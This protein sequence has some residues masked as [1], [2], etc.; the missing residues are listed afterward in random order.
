[1][2][3]IEIPRC[4]FTEYYGSAASIS[5]I[6]YYMNVLRSKKEFPFQ[7]TGRKRSD[8]DYARNMKQL[9]LVDMRDGSYFLTPR[10]QSILIIDQAVNSKHPW[11]N[12]LIKFC[13][14]KSLADFD[15][16][17]IASILWY[18]QV[19][20]EKSN[21]LQELFFPSSS[22]RN[23]RDHWLRLHL[24]L[25]KETDLLVYYIKRYAI[26]SD[27]GK[28]A[29]IAHERASNDV[30]PYF[31][32]FIGDSYFGVRIKLSENASK[33]LVQ[34]FLP[35]SLRLYSQLFG[36]EEIGNIEPVKS[37]LLANALKRGKFVPEPA[38][39]KA[40]LEIFLDEEIPLYRVLS[41]MQ[42]SGRGI[43]QW[44]EASLEYYPDFNLYIALRKFAR[45]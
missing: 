42:I 21:R 37:L 10:G 28:S 3:K 27:E 7:E 32:D 25:A 29:K 6:V 34:H 8:F 33:S 20:K 18:S 31:K 44:I 14:L 43:F 12:Q 45:S 36:D 19:L 16:Q 11:K 22:E 40:M 2:N 5:K 17:C 39:S 9:G 30:N 15:W 38:L 35:E 26:H 24:K 23:F 1:M 41:D 4:S 13:I